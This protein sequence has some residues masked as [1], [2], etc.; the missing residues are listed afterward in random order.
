M[1]AAT[2]W[3]AVVVTASL[4]GIG[5]WLGHSFN[6]RRRAEIELTVAQKRFD[7]Y[8]RLWTIMGDAPPM[9]SVVG[10]TPLATEPERRRLFDKLTA[11]YFRDG[12]GM[13]LN[14]PTRTIYF[15]A[16][17]NLVLPTE[18]LLPGARDLVAGSDD[19][20][21]A[22]A[23]LSIR[24]LSLLRTATRADVAVFARIYGEPLDDVDREFLSACGADLSRPPWRAD[25]DAA[26]ATRSGR[27]LGRKEPTIG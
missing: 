26:R 4:G 6:R 15:R 8:A 10:E 9:S 16:K 23:R 21:A 22:R 27:A 12:H 24:Q 20:G 13:L 19:P 17:E 5:L 2:D 1:S 25:G 14:E 7:A 3:A 18:R 11:W